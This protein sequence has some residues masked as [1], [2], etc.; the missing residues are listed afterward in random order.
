MPLDYTL[1]IIIGYDA[2]TLREKVDLLAAGQRLDE[3][4]ELRSLSAL[5]EKIALLRLIGRLDEAFDMA[6]A[7]LRQARFT[8]SRE[9]L[10]ASRIRR[11]QVMQ[12]QGKLDDAASELTH[13]VLEAETHEWS[14]V[15]AFARENR[16]KVLFEQGDLEG[17]LTDLTAAVFLREKAGASVDQLEGSLVAVAVVESIIAERGQ[18]SAHRSHRGRASRATVCL[19]Y[20]SPSP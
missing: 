15:A 8:G 9:E 5:N 10:A 3:L 1:P 20:T 11:A 16:G 18:G 6:N 14:A 2:V 7:A 4:G 13:C 12:F 17:A 19:L